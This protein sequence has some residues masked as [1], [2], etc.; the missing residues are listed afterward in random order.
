VKTKFEQ[1]DYHS[2]NS[3][4]SGDRQIMLFD[5]RTEG[6]HAGYIQHLVRYWCEQELPG[7]L[8]VVVTP[9]F[10]EQHANVVD[11]GLGCSQ[12]N[13]NFVAITLEEQA[14]LGSLYSFTGRL[15]RAFQEWHLIRKYTTSLGSTHCLLMFFDSV[16]SRMVLGVKPPCP[17]SGIFFRP[18]LHYSNFANYVPSQIER[19]W[20]W[21]EKLGL[22]R[23]LRSGYFQN[24]FCLDPVA[25]EYLEQL[26][27]KTNVLH[28]PDPVQIYDDS[29]SQLEKLKE[30]LSIDPGRR[31]FLLF[32]AL[33]ERKGIY[34][35]LEAV[36]TLP[37]N[38]CQKSCLLLIGRIDPQIREKFKASLAEISRFLP[39]QIIIRDEFVSD[40]QMRLYFRI[41][42][43]ILAP[44]QR[45]LG[46]SGILV[47]AAAAEKPVLSS[48]YGL[49]GEITRRYSL[50]LTVD[51]AVP[52]EI[53]K[54]L[55]HFLFESPASLCDRLKMKQFAEQN[56]A[57]QFASTIFQHLIVKNACFS[58]GQI[59]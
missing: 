9:K 36:R 24:L 37:P 5:L 22:S 6:H 12:K 21:R 58:V 28:L 55:T 59:S 48:D 20:Q 23:I 52:S 54:G 30:S 10:I 56:T 32:G 35:L 29:Q 45:H 34:Q 19:I 42:D 41:V 25:V 33:C 47:Q 38:H 39:I 16:F 43:V 8:D 46:M 53:A 14:A 4:C 51:S 18:M 17:M 40:Q 27:S 26:P 13:I 3:R 49:M 44:Y 50:G 1:S 15:R 31:I 57:E 2:K 7:R 11:I